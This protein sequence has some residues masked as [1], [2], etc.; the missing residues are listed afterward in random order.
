MDIA[1]IIKEEG[2]LKRLQENGISHAMLFQSMDDRLNKVMLIMTALSINYKTYELFNEESAEYLKIKNNADIDIKI[3]P[4]NNEKLLVSD[5]NEI[6]DEV[7]IKPAEHD[8]KVFIINNIEA[9]TEQ[10][11][12][13]LL[14][15][16]EE[17][18]KNVYFLISCQDDNR[19]LQT[20]KSRCQKIML[21][22]LPKEEFDLICKNPLAGMISEG[23]IGLYEEYSKKANL[24]EVVETVIKLVTELKNSGQV[25]KFSTNLMKYREDIEL[26]FQIYIRSLEDMIKIKSEREDLCSMPLYIDALKSVESEFSINAICEINSL[27]S[28]FIKKREANVNEQVALENLLLKIL[29][30]KYIC[31]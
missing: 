2:Y 6:T 27:V 19:V 5:S 14:K 12:N 26:I 4:K 21:E 3:Y 25:L 9:S 22:K 7:Y 8:N 13:K 17:P 24:E 18:P 20:I 29:E 31:K 30:V 15:V 28:E 10:A 16:L 1:E 23:Y 11:Q